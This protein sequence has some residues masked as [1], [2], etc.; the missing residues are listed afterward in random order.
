MRSELPIELA[1][2]DWEGTT[3]GEICRSG[4]GDIQTGP[5]GSQLHANDY[6]DEGIPSIMPQDTIDGRIDVSNIARITHAD[7]ERLSRY[8]VRNG[9]IVY[10]RRG[11]IRRRALIRDEQDGWLCG[12]GCLRVRVGE[13]ALPDYVSAYLGHPAIQ[14]WIERHAVGATMLNL[15]TGILSSVP[16]ALPRRH[17]QERIASVLR[18]LDEKIDSNHR[19][20]ALFEETAATMFGAQFVDFVGESDF[21][22]TELGRLPMEWTVAPIGDV[23]TV[24]GGGTPSTKESRY[25][26]G[27]THCWATPKDLAGMRSTVL[28]DT[29]RHITDDGVRRISSRLLPQRTVLL[30]SRAPVGY[31]AM[32]MV[33]V[34]VNQG[35]IAIPPS[36]SV[37]SEFVL[38]WLRE[39]MDRIKAHA[40]GTTFAEISKRAFRPL[41]MPVPPARA[42]T[43]FEQAARPMFDL[44]AGHEREIRALSRIRDSLLPKLVS[45]EIRVPDASDSAE[46]LGALAEETPA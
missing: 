14:A 45:G 46:L 42:L 7:A 23:L 31:T 5:F 17:E 16:V 30:S 10:S 25:W 11:D 21:V 13:G 32:S 3:L 26:D 4:G 24:V 8:R 12:T 35:F 39:N 1:A 18:A 28:L 43:E 37:P 20:V 29:A 27:G 33:E 2:P 9:D 40:G 36:D 19:L 38:L 44:V 41:L 15:N 22:E 6:V 34:A